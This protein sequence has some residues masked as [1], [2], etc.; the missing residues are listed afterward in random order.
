MNIQNYPCCIV[1]YF[2]M[3]RTHIFYLCGAKHGKHCVP[4]RPPILYLRTVAPGQHCGEPAHLTAQG[5]TAVTGLKMLHSI[6]F[7]RGQYQQK[8]LV[9]RKVANAWVV[10]PH[11]RHV[12]RYDV[13]STTKPLWRA[14]ISK[15]QSA[16][17]VCTNPLLDIPYALQTLSLLIFNEFILTCH[18]NSPSHEETM[19]FIASKSLS[20]I[21]FTPAKNEQHAHGVVVNFHPNRQR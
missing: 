5:H 4:E 21:M 18:Q 7:H 2:L 9:A 17:A 8:I 12:R 3:I 13:G 11:P 1:P 6:S 14:I 10:Q 15:L 19:A 16:G 20:V